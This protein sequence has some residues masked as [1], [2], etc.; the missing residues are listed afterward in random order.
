MTLAAAL[1]VSAAI[2]G[3][4][5]AA[6]ATVVV[7]RCTNSPADQVALQSALDTFSQV[8]VRGTC[9]GNWSISRTGALS[10]AAPGA[11][12]HGAGGGTVLTIR[13]T[14]FAI[15][16]VTITGGTGN[17]STLGGG[18]SA[19]LSTINLFR[20]VVT[21]NRAG[22]GAGIY[23]TNGTLLATSS[24]ISANTTDP[25]G[26]GGGG[27]GILGG[28]ADINLTDSIVSNNSAVSDGGGILTTGAFTLNRR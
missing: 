20:T 10:G 6:A 15:S 11:T 23:L 5:P 13:N 17:F 8:R 1:T 18:I 22:G 27:G 24:T 16:D 12:L 21:R 25:F 28:A 4:G 26:G 7:V 19:D 2:A 9:L 14:S 3:A